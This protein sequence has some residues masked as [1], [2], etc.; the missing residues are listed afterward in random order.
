MLTRFGK[1]ALPIVEY[2]QTIVS[3]TLSSATR[4]IIVACRDTYRSL[5]KTETDHLHTILLDIHQ[6]VSY[7][8]FECLRNFHE[9][10]SLKLK[11]KYASKKNKKLHKLVVLREAN[12]QASTQKKESRVKKCRRFKRRGTATLQV[13]SNKSSPVTNT[14]V[15]LSDTEL[16]QEQAQVLALGPKFCPTPRSLDSQRL[17]NDVT[18]G[19]RRVRLKELFYQPDKEEQGPPRFYKKTFYVPPSGRDQA[20]DAYCNTIESLV[21]DFSPNK[22]FRDNLSPPQRKAMGELRQLVQDRV[23]RISQADKGGAVVVQ[24]TEDYIREANRQL[25]DTVHYKTVSNDPTPKITT[26]SN[27]LVKELPSNGHIDENTSKWAQLDPS[28]V[29][30]HI[31]YHLPKI[32]KTLQNPPGRPIVSGIQGPTEKLSKL[33]DFWL[34]DYVTKLPSYV[35]DTT[36]ML[37]VIEE[38]NI[39]FGPFDDSVQLVTFDVVSLYSNIPHEDMKT[40]ISHFLTLRPDHSLPP[41]ESILTIVD[42]ILKNNYFSFEGQTYHQV[43]GTAMGTPMAPTV[44][45]LFMGLL[46]SNILETSP[47]TVSQDCWKRFIDDILVLWRGTEEGLLQFT[48]FLNSIH[49][50]I[51][52]TMTSS[53]SQI[54]FL[55][56][57][58]KLRN[59]FIT[60]DVYSKPTDAHAYLHFSSCHPRHCVENIP[61][62]QFL[63]IRRLC[64]E[65]EEFKHQCEAM[66]QNFKQRG[67]PDTVINKSEKKAAET[68]R[69]STLNY[70]QKTSANRVPVVV[71]HHPHN[72]PLRQWLSKHLPILHSSEKMKQA[73]PAPP[74]VGE[75][76][77]R[78]LRSILMPS[79]LPCTEQSALLPSGCFKCTK[80]RCVLCKEHVVETRQFTSTTTGER[81]TI[82]SHHT[83]ETTNIVY[84]LWCT[85]C[86]LQY[87]GETKNSLKQRF[88]QHRSDINLRK[89]TCTYIIQHF[90]QTDHTLSDL[91]CLVIEKVFG[92]SLE[93]RNKREDFWRKKLRT[94]YPEGLNILDD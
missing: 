13:D 71:T 43:T 15:N 36:H 7:V 93:A 16:T 5:V 54:S 19:C 77:C 30:T 3:H 29:R 35:Q 4:E 60:T 2:L 40:A 47:V 57:L 56:I 14:V 21:S 85:K 45:N 63:R 59:G 80:S 1:D 62:S 27:K 70:K 33:V 52:F 11:R 76:N 17:K 22:H 78:S 88:Y 86:K 94:V 39:Q 67:Y 34:R 10:L 75:R 44:A 38:W 46:E 9:N 89:G 82:R 87:V 28:D 20:L 26:S 81:F 84:L 50:T 48:T 18:E 65:D 32:H 24:N 83:C 41:V 58:L 72:P 23:I 42:H 69:L 37:R 91:R 6:S 31:F 74:V 66:K 64:S 51:K 92:M 68:P 53:H 90:N 55:D 25:T 12:G 49:P 73:V 61:F 79:C 8:E